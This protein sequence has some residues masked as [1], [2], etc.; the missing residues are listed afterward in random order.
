MSIRPMCTGRTA[1]L[2]PPKGYCASSL[3]AVL[4]ERGFSPKKKSNSVPRE[5][6]SPGSSQHEWYSLG[7]RVH[8]LVDQGISALLGDSELAVWYRDIVC[9]RQM[10][11]MDGP[12]WP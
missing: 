7:R 2:R 3:Y 12:A 10:T 5:Q 4:A 6:S 9:V 11:T 8:R 1:A